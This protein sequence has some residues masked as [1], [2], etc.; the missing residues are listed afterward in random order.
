MPRYHKTW[1]FIR[2]F[3]GIFA[4]RPQLLDIAPNMCHDIDQTNGW[5]DLLMNVTVCQINPFDSERDDHLNALKQHLEDNKSDFLLLP[6]MCFSNWL[7]SS[8]NPDPQLWQD[9][10]RSH[11]DYINTL[12]DLGVMTIVGTRPIISS[13]GDWHNQAFTWDA[14]SGDALPW[15]EKYYLP[16][17]PGYYEQRWYERGAK[18]F[19]TAQTGGMR[20]GVQICTEMWFYEWARQYAAAQIDVLCVPRASPHSE[21][22]KWLAGGRVAA[23][24]SGAFCLSSNLWAPITKDPATGNVTDL[25]G[26]SWIV[27]PEGN[28]LATTSADAPFATAEIDLEWARASKKTYPRYVPE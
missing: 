27:D 18:A 20:L 12:S 26:L 10:V 3:A 19:G 1:N 22:D 23:I 9:A 28:V 17:E 13:D 14:K 7:A 2:L 15:R 25:G 4:R 11:Q 8:P 5:G 24:C 21:T 6:E 16:D